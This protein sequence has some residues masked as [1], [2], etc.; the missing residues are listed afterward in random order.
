MKLFQLNRREDVT[1][2]SGTG[3]VAEGVL[4]E[5]GSAVVRWLAEPFRSTTIWPA[6]NA[7]EA[8]RAVH[9]HDGR[10]WFIWL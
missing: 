8:I 10:T 6:P 3:V 5:D 4:F 1:G 2:V 7:Y 9:S